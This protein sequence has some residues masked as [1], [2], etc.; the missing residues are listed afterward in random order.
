[1][2]KPKEKKGHACTNQKK[3]YA[4]WSNCYNPQLHESGWIV[5]SAHDSVSLLIVNCHCNLFVGGVLPTVIFTSWFYGASHIYIYIYIYFE[6]NFGI[7]NINKY[8]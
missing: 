1:M 5:I 8:L 7:L 2:Q 4:G 3:R 6:V